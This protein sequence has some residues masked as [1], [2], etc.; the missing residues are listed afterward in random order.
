[1]I[2]AHMVS[3]DEDALTCDLASEY[4][5]LNWRELPLSLVSTLAIGLSEDSRIKKKI[6]GT[7]VDTD[8][9]LLAMLIDSVNMLIYM[10]TKD[11][12]DGI[13]RPKSIATILT[14]RDNE[15]QKVGFSTIEEFERAKRRII[16]GG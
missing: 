16:E 12:K 6:T 14:G 11:A 3:V 15:D 10:N 8:T 5:I 1:M 2:L 9:L 13:N 4:K 7:K